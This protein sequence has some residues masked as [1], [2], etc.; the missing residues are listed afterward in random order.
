MTTSGSQEK[1][2]EGIRLYRIYERLALGEALSAPE[3]AQEF[4]VSERSIRRD[5]RDLNEVLSHSRLH[6]GAVVSYDVGKGGYAMQGGQIEWLSHED[7]FVMAK[8]LLESRA[9]TKADL[10]MLLKKLGNLCTPDQAKAVRSWIANESYHYVETR[11]S[12]AITSKLWDLS[13]AIRTR[14]VVKLTYVREYPHQVDTTKWPAEREVEPVG[15]VFSEFYF[16]LLAYFHDNRFSYPTI[17]RLDRI[18][19]DYCVTDEHFPSFDEK[20]RFEEGK[21]RKQVQFMYTGKLLSVTFKFWGASLDAVLDRLP[22]ARVIAQEGKVATI[23]AEVFGKGIIMWFL[24]QAQYL[25]VLAP[26]E[27]REQMRQTVREM[28]GVYGK[29]T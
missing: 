29:G 20:D 4:G 15:I 12:Q 17:Y 2:R 18:A 8:I 19:D 3:L 23:R 27:L 26:D 21:F 6:P 14:S 28:A 22:T 7:V 10:D 5:V 13:Q 1:V 9:F 25:E 16:Y 24:S 11:H